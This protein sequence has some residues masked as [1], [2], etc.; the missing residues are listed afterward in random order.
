[1]SVFQ[2][3]SLLSLILMVPC[4]A[5]G[6]SVNGDGERQSP[7]MESGAVTQTPPHDEAQRQESADEMQKMTLLRPNWQ[8][9]VGRPGSATVF[10]RWLAKQPK[11]YQRMIESAST[12]AEL[13]ES[14]EEFLASDDA[15][16]AAHREEL[17]VKLA[18]MRA[19]AQGQGRHDDEGQR[20]E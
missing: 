17:D 20:L 4:V 9:I 11:A 12:A 13:N 14:I 18:E 5:L 7:Q 6:G 10:R 15:L 2:R 16:V 3:C 1:M 19:R 8:Q